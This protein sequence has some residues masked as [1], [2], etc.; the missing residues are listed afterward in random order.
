[1]A[2][3]IENNK[4]IFDE[5]PREGQEVN[6]TVSTQQSVNGFSDP[7]GYYPRR[8]NEPDTNRLAVNDSR[9]QHPVVQF[10]KQRVDDLTGEP[11]TPYNAQYRY[12]SLLS[13]FC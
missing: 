3:R 1:M 13:W 5:P 6:V 7:R 11:K 2:Y 4:I 10:K 9:N 8:L 12:K